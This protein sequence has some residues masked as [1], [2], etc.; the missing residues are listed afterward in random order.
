MPMQNG[1][2]KLQ[3]HTAIGAGS[4]VV[5]L[6]DGQLW[7]GDSGLYY[8][9]SYEVRGNALS[10]RLRTDRHSNLGQVQSVLGI[11]QATIALEGDARDNAAAMTGT[12]REVP[13]VTLQAH[14]SRI[15]S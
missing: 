6:Q 11:D 15:C 7:G 4:G 5:M 9:G 8:V 3:F 12:A 1:L 10:A 2:Y 13:G 14:L